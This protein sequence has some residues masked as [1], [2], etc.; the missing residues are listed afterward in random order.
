MQRARGDGGSHGGGGGAAGAPALT[1]QEDAPLC[2]A[3][4]TLA[5]EDGL[6]EIVGGAGD[7]E[8]DD[9]FPRHAS[10]PVD[11]QFEQP[12]LLV[13][14]M[15]CREISQQ[16]FPRVEIERVHARARARPDQREP[17]Q[18]V[19]VACPRVVAV[20]PLDRE[21]TRECLLVAF[22]ECL[23][24]AFIEGGDEGGDD[25]PDGRL[26]AASGQ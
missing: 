4:A 22:R 15:P 13:L 25:A 9:G 12:H 17:A 20:R 2:A 7:T 10:L 19:G 23:L 26:V 24:I 18:L 3:H 1:P 14:L 8:V 16:G 5:P 6:R 11:R 21:E